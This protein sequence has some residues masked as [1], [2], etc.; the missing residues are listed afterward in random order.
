MQCG[1]HYSPSRSVRNVKIGLDI[2]CYHYFHP[3]CDVDELQKILIFFSL[4][5]AFSCTLHSQTVSLPRSK[6]L[7][8]SSVFSLTT[9]YR[10]PYIS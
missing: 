9:K 10:T 2:L 8:L 5:V 3:D 6:W 7:F 4:F 1:S